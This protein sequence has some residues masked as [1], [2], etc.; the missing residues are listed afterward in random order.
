MT[1][2]VVIEIFTVKDDTLDIQRI[3]EWL[4]L[5]N[6]TVLLTHQIDAAYWH[7][8]N[9]FQLPGGVQL[10]LILNLPIVFL[11]LI[12]LQSLVLGRRS[13]IVISW[14]LVSSGLFAFGIHSFFLLQGDDAF[15]LPVS[16]GLLA[17]TLVLSVAQAVT[18]FKLEK[19]LSL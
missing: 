15:K 12:G 11:V 19:K 4:Y 1:V 16:V 3:H 9:L 6:A 17:A 10:F 14:L 2:K 7:E 8:W 18:L 5:I 13:G